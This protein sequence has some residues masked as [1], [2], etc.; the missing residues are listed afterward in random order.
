MTESNTV[1]ETAISLLE[2]MIV[3]PFSSV[4]I[5]HSP[6]HLH[7]V[8]ACIVKGVAISVVAYFARDESIM[9]HAHKSSCV[10]RIGILQT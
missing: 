10:R 5:D 8:V 4:V 2:H 3:N 1:L 6:V 7:F 9:S